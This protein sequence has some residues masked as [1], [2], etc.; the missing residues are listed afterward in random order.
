MRARLLETKSATD[1]QPQVG[2][3][4]GLDRCRYYGSLRLHISPQGRRI[5][6]PRNSAHFQ[7]VGRIDAAAP[8]ARDSYEGSSWSRVIVGIDDQEGDAGRTVSAISPPVPTR[9]GLVCQ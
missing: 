3:F 6:L 1:G 7:D 5:S 8:K 4:S 9:C 2:T